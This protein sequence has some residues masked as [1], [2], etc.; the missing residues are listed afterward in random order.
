MCLSL[1]EVKLLYNFFEQI[2]KYSVA[3]NN[4]YYLDENYGGF[5][6]EVPTHDDYKRYIER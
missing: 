3:V 1:D 5:L 4:L 6:Q 2:P